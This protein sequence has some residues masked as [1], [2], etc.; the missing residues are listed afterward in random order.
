MPVDAR[1]GKML[2]MAALLRCV[3]PALTVA[4]YLSGRSP[5]SSP[6]DKRQVAS[7]VHRKIAP[8]FLSDHLTVVKAFNQWATVLATAG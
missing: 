6:P 2:I 1:L 3:D 4:A 8:E 5:L 7:A